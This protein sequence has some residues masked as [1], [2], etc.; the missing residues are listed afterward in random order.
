MGY[1][2]HEIPGRLRVKIPNLKRNPQSARDIQVLLKNLPGIESISTN[3]VTGSIIV[4]YDPELVNSGAIVNVSRTR[5]IYRSGKGVL[6]QGAQREHHGC[7]GPSGV[8]G[9]SRIR[10][11]S[12]PSGHSLIHCHCFYLGPLTYT[13]SSSRNLSDSQNRIISQL[14]PQH[15]RFVGHFPRQLH[16]GS[17]EMPVCG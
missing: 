16:V 11:G 3:T 13:H 17:S 12:S 9:H 4:R 10:I 7:R 6:Q 14:R 2:L 5:R 15:F 1:Y 8:Q